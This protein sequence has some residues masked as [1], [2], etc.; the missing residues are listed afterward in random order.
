MKNEYQILLDEVR[1]SYASVVWTHKIQE[2]QADIYRENYKKLEISNILVASGT[3]CGIVSTIFCD[4]VIAKIISAGLSF[5]SL[6]ITAYFKSFD[7]KG[8]EHQNKEYANK[9]LIIRNRLLHIIGDI[10]M[11]KR[12]VDEINVDYIKVIDALNELYMEAPST[13]QEAVNAASEALKVNNEY[14]YTDEEI[15]NFLPPTLRGKI[16]N[17]VYYG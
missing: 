5:I 2:K 11:Q 17:K 7:I 1:Q 16:V 9:L 10:H 6:V 14:T 3:S 4:N 15:D 13:T 8:M 12:N